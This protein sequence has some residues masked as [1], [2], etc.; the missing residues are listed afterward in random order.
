MNEA[1]FDKYQALSNKRTEMIEAFEYYEIHHKESV[2]EAV[3]KYRDILVFWREY[4]RSQH[5]IEG[6]TKSEY[7]T[8]NLIGKLEEMERTF[9]CSYSP[10][11][12]SRS[13]VEKKYHEVITYLFMLTNDEIID[14][15]ATF[16]LSRL[17]YNI[18]LLID[19]FF[20]I[21][22]A[23]YEDFLT[24]IRNHLN[25]CIIISQLDYFSEYFEELLGDFNDD[26]VSIKEV[27]PHILNVVGVLNFKCHK[28]K[29]AIQFFMIALKGFN[30]MKIDLQTNDEYFQ[31][32]LL[33]AYCYEY[34]H[35]FESAIECLIGFGYKELLS[36]SNNLE[37]YNL[38]SEKT[39][40]SGRKTAQKIINKI[41]ERAK[42]E[43][44][45]NLL[46]L[47][48]QRDSDKVNTIG[49]IHEVLH[50]LG[51][52]LNELGI[53]K[54][55]SSQISE[56]ETVVNLL[57]LARMI[58]LE[59][60]V[61]NEKCEDFQ[62]CLYMVYGEA[63]DYDI[64]LNRINEITSKLELSSIQ[65]VNYY[66]ENLFYKFLILNQSNKVILSNDALIKSQ[67]AYL[68]F[69]KF[70]QRR[71]DYDALI[72]IEIIKFRCSIIG[73][74]RTEKDDQSILGS[75]VD[76]KNQ[77]EGQSM[78]GIK[79]S[80]KLNKW[81]VQEYNKTIALYEFLVKYFQSSGID[82]NALYNFA[83][84]FTYFR[85]VFDENTHLSDNETD[86]RKIIQST[87][88]LIM[89]DV[90]SP[91]SI[92][93]LAPLTSAV[94]YQHQTKNLLVL[95][96]NLFQEN[97][98][99]T[100]TDFSDK[101]EQFQRLQEIP[102]PSQ[103]VEDISNWLFN[104]SEYKPVFLVSQYSSAS[105]ERYYYADNNGLVLER[106]IQNTESLTKIL[107][108]ISSLRA[109]KRHSYCQ[110]QQTRCCISLIDNDTINKEIF[111]EKI[112]SILNE[113][114]IPVDTYRSKHF[115]VE[116]RISKKQVLDWSILGFE[117]SLSEIQGSE[118]VHYLCGRDES[119]ENVLADSDGNYCFFGNDTV[120][121]NTA[122]KDMLGFQNNYL[123]L[124]SSRHKER[125]V[126]IDKLSKAKGA[127]F[128]ISPKSIEKLDNSSHL[129]EQ[130]NYVC[131]ST[132][133]LR[134]HTL[135]IACEFKDI[136]DVKKKLQENSAIQREITDFIIAR[137]ILRENVSETKNSYISD[138]VQKM[139]E[140]GVDTIAI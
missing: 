51:H 60:A 93:L 67:N 23:K 22:E 85:N 106:P 140:Y 63:K 91:Q 70:S 28:Y 124:F 26:F 89:D 36:F 66:M 79:P 35:D 131:N 90:F 24:N 128:F 8:D 27:A 103:K 129:F 135:F 76:L 59:V 122:T 53:K 95:E 19:C 112:Y 117:E 40:E 11:E 58:M 72:H 74:L 101:L 5:S 56:R 20:P 100:F 115:V 62:T 14:K 108:T 110:N 88:E 125:T 98:E 17:L 29:E 84:R 44:N 9:I 30:Y 49:D 71:Y 121:D 50:S 46:Y 34:N 80:A 138:V 116:C 97:N 3:S 105:S 102:R 65:N 41:I 18:S 31:T 120:D 48:L 12:M 1:V 107:I 104:H 94:P 109:K 133:E 136:Q 78:F 130:I 21:H 134:N 132:C 54:K 4:L 55:M 68:E 83:C 82:L 15:K 92:F 6:I 75:L 32:K 118:I 99:S 73:I 87:I 111:T 123:R 114:F 69:K 16:L 139:K 137:I 119:F 61:Q 52:C 113:L 13:I 38:I 77:P 126:N 81:I 2:Q 37:I 45:N 47:G 33:L 127:I 64:C 7:T 42:Q 25:K 86:K 96:K 39:F 57:Y 43:K 10:T